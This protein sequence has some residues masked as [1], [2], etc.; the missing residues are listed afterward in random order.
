MIAITT[1]MV[2]RGSRI[3]ERVSRVNGVSGPRMYRAEKRA[4]PWIAAGYK[5]RRCKA[6][7]ALA[8]RWVRLGE[9]KGVA[10]ALGMISESAPRSPAVI[11]EPRPTSILLRIMFLSFPAFHSGA[12]PYQ[13]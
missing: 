6:Q 13:L 7:R 12:S 10:K 5:H 8:T 3:P 9:R 1:Q 11:R 4:E 2:G